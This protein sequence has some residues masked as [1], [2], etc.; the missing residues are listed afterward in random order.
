MAGRTKPFIQVHLCEEGCPGQLSDEVLVH[1]SGFEETELGRVPWLTD[2]QGPRE[3]EEVLDKLAELRKE[4]E[5]MEK[6]SR[7]VQKKAKKKEKKRKKKQEE[8]EGRLRQSPKRE[9]DELD[10]GQKPLEDICKYTGTDPEP[11]R[12]ARVLKRARRIRKTGKKKRKRKE[13]GSSPP[14]ASSSSYSSQSSLTDYGNEMRAFSKK[15]RNYGL[16]G[17][18]VR[19][20]WQLGQSRRSRS[21]AT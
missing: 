20:Q 4:Q 11:A 5:R 6:D 8:D 10:V 7:E 15:R 21:S 18:V 17:A 14:K 2:L 1:A 9:S 16:S 12:R 19:E 13:K 3:D